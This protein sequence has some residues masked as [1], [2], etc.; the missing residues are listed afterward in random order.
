[1]QLKDDITELKRGDGVRPKPHKLVMLLSV[2]ELA[3][4]GLIPPNRIYYD[5]ILKTIFAN[6]FVLIADEHDWCQPGL[7]YF[8]LRSAPFWFLQ[9]KEGQEVELAQMK[10]PGGGDR[11]ITE[12]IAYAYLSDYAFGVF[13]DP[14]ARRDLRIFLSSLINPY[15]NSRHLQ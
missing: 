13:A 3:D 9:A 1:M 15:A 6:Y 8:H 12:T 5:P 14:D 11:K 4:R 2:V 10:K 7:P